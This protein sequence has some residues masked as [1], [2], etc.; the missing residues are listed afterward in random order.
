MVDHEKRFPSETIRRRLMGMLDGSLELPRSIWHHT[1][2]RHLD[3]AEQIGNRIPVY[4]DSR[5]WFDLR[6][7]DDGDS[8]GKYAADLLA[9][10]REAV[11]NGKIFCPISANTFIEIFKHADKSVRVRSAQIIDELSLGISLLNSEQLSEAELEWFISNPGNVPI[12]ARVVPIWT[13]IA[14]SLGVLVPETSQIP[15][16]AMLALQVA[17]FDELWGLPL[18]HFAMHSDDL[19]DL[20]MANAAK[21][22]TENNRR[23][24]HEVIDFETV[25]RSEVSGSADLYAPMLSEILRRKAAEQGIVSPSSS[26][27]QLKI[28]ANVVGNVQ[29][30]G[31]S[32]LSL[33]SFHIR[34][35]LY[36]I[37]RINKDR[38][39][40]PNDYFDIEHAISGVGYCSAFF[41][42]GSLTTALTQNPLKLNKLY[43]CRVT[44]SYTEAAAIVSTLCG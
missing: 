42:E 26:E 25:Y 19:P 16:Q 1:R 9:L 10:L 33:R 21:H 44:N 27:E 35:S 43:D 2:Q 24:S 12:N 37:I 18:A 17:T 40:K 32:R 13:K 5:F 31:K 29:L 20:S 39:F 4:L 11:R 3:L 7:A 8:K 28:F 23:S 34:A 22:L 38:R 41:S 6:R 36:S 30:L 14:Y 15:Q